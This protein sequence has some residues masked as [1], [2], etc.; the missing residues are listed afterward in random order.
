MYVASSGVIVCASR[1]VNILRIIVIFILIS[2]F[3]GSLV[4][5]SESNESH[6]GSIK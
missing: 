2:H 5:Y 4:V 1:R 3:L 6:F